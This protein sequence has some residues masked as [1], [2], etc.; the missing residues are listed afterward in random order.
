VDADRYG[1]SAVNDAAL[2]DL[3]GEERNKGMQRRLQTLLADRLQVKVHR[4]TREMTEYELVV[5][6]SG[7]KLKES[8]LGVGNAISVNCGVIEGTR[9]TLSISRWR[10]RDN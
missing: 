2:K 3:G 10:S 5:A 4:E 9:T 7:S 6:K 8:D 1:L